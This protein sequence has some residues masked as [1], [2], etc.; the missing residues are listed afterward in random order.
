MSFDHIN[1]SVMSEREIIATSFDR[2]NEKALAVSLGDIEL[3][4]VTLT[5]TVVKSDPTTSD[6]TTFDQWYHAIALLNRV[7]ETLVSSVHLAR[8]RV[9]GDTFVLLRVA[10]E[11]AAVAVHVSRDRV[12]FERYM[13]PSAKKYKASHAI[14]A[15]RSLIPRLPEVWGALSQAAIHPNVHTFGPNLEEGSGNPVIHISGRNADPF[16]DRLS[17]RGVS[18]AAALVFRATELVL[19]DESSTEPGWLQLPGDAMRATA[20]AEC[21][22]ERRY[23]EFTSWEQEPAQRAD[24]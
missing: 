2:A 18:L 22:V 12:A 13:E 6:S 11:S 21:L 7:R 16:Q 9:F 17:L 5:F 10:V 8:H 24:E 3:I 1:D 20:T 19:F 23:Q 4:R 14:G 15:V